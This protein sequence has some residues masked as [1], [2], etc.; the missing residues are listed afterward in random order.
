MKLTQKL[1]Y[2]T[3]LSLDLKS[4]SNTQFCEESRILRLCKLGSLDEAITLLNSTNPAQ[5]TRKSLVY[6]S[7]LQTST[8]IHSFLHGIQIHCRII[9]SGLEDDS[10]VGNSLFGLYFKTAPHLDEARKAFD[11]L[12][13]KDVIS[14]TS[15]ISGYVKVGRPRESVELFRDMLDRG[16]EANAFALSAT[17][18][19]CSEL[20]YLGLGRCC[21]GVVLRAGFD[22]NC[23]IASA[24]VDMYGKNDEF[25]DA[26]K[27]FDEL[28]E[29]DAVCWSSIISALTRNDLFEEALK[30]FFVMQRRHRLVP[31]EFT[32]GSVLTACG[33]LGRL[34]QGKQVHGKV[35]IA[36]LCGYVVAESSLVDMYGKCGRTIESKRVFDRMHNKNS[37]TRCALLGGYCENGNFESVVELFRAMAMEQQH[38]LYSFGTVLRACAGLAAVIQ[39]KEVHCQYLRRRGGWRHVIVESALVD[40]YA[41]CGHI[42]YARRIF[43]LMTVKNLISWNSMICGLAQNGHGGE[44]VQVY[45]RMVEEGVKPEYIT[46][47]GVL[48]ACSHAGLVDQGREYFCSMTRRYG[49]KPGIEHFNC[50]VD[51]F[52]RA[53]LVEEAENLIEKAAADSEELDAAASSSS[54]WPAL[55]GACMTCRNFV[56]AERIATKMIKYD[57]ENHLSYVH[58]AN[59]YKAAGRWDDAMKIRQFMKERGLGKL[60]GRSWVEQ[61]AATA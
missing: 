57:P 39:G 19:A 8:K 61:K 17:I 4:H 20:R 10:F 29:P 18:K 48:F 46:F 37:V 38:D 45:N 5:I 28:H 16:V 33:N 23:V 2:T 50:M 49:V 9:R 14:W 56:A 13:E 6:A 41:K 30:L 53:G 44:A 32:Y 59:V 31:D 52:G 34:K 25:V 36:G 43:H 15:M 58:L 12:N 21:H 54:A 11:G 27:V 26:R 60:P 51:L 55:L 47:V 7:L 24:L 3:V 1:H 22:P 42:D 40:L 35:V